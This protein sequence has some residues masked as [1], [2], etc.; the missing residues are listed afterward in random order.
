MRAFSSAAWCCN[1][2]GW[3]VT[4]D[5]D[6]LHESL[7]AIDRVFFGDELDGSVH[8]GWSRWRPAKVHFRYGAYLSPLFEGRTFFARGPANIVINPVLAHDWVPDSVVLFTIFHECLHAQRGPK[9]D[10]AFRLAERSFPRFEFVSQ[11]GDE[12]IDRLL[13]ATPPKVRRA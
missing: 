13:A 9:H 4:R 11:W 8:I 12:N 3:T 1:C 5:L 7:R 6:W 2:A 10:A